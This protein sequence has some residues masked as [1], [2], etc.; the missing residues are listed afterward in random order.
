[1]TIKEAERLSIMKQVES[2][3]LKQREA[4]ESLGLSLR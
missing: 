2:K 1:M 4:S 3:K